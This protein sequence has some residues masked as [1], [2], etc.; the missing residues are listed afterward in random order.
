VGATRGTVTGVAPGMVT[1][2]ANFPLSLVMG[3]TSVTVIP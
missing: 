1:L 3:Q 2:T